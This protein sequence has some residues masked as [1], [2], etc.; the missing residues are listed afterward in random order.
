MKRATSQKTIYAALFVLA[1]VGTA[2]A[3]DPTPVTACGT[4]ITVAG[5]YRL[6][7]DLV[8]CSTVGVEIQASNTTL[9]LNGHTISGGAVGAVGVEVDA[10]GGNVSVIGPGVL[11]GFFFGID[12]GGSNLVANVT[13][14]QSFVGFSIVH[15]GSNNV[16]KGNLANGNTYGFSS[17]G[18]GNVWRG[19]DASSNGTG[20]AVSGAGNEIRGN[21]ANANSQD[22]I[23]VSDGSTGNTIRGNTTLGNNT[24][25]GTFF[26]LEDDNANCDS[27]VWQ[28]NDFA[29]SNQ[30]C[31]Q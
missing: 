14:S 18:N 11:T 22:G 5:K 15:S 20:F 4:V 7:N 19:N 12:L 30:A 13:V 25:G 17:N 31:I 26:D 16:F 3:D 1:I 29:T 6:A 28:G 9:L 23:Q 21:T 10:G 8:S 24:S 27:N 2:S